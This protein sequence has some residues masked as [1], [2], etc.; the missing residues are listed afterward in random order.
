MVKKSSK[1]VTKPTVPD[2]L[3]FRSSLNCSLVID[4]SNYKQFVKPPASMATGYQA[5]D[6]NRYPFGSLPFA[7]PFPFKI[8]PRNEWTARIQE[9]EEK[10]AKLSTLGDY[11]SIRRLNQART[12]YCWANCVVTAVHYLRAA[13]NLETVALSSAS[14]AGPITK[15]KNVGGW[16][17]DALERFASHG[18]VPQPLWPNAEISS[19][20]ATPANM[21]EALKYRVTD[22]I[23]LHPRNF[24]EVMT[25]LLMKL[26]VPFGVLWWGHAICGVD[27]VV[28]GNNEYGVLIDNSWDVTWGDNGR[29]VLTEPK[30]TPD[31]AICPT[32]AIAA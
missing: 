7:K 30:A 8:I 14:I 15:Y 24:D 23:D 19:R 4:D 13:A 1:P 3:P 28:L 10:N 2:I 17:S 6:Y 22:W 29:A 20:Y 5:R 9:I 31:E 21:Q 18:A 32:V 12:N 26:P 16:P 25:C 11:M 27:P